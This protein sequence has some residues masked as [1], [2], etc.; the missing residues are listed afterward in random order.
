MGMYQSFQ[1]DE[2][3]IKITRSYLD[4]LSTEELI[5]LAD[6]HG[7]DIPLDLERVFVIEELLELAE[8]KY[9]TEP[10]EPSDV[11]AEASAPLPVEVYDYPDQSVLPKQ[12]NLTYMDVLIRDPLWAYVFWEIKMS[13]KEALEAS[14]D[15]GG[16]YLKVSSFKSTADTKPA[17][18]QSFA[19]KVNND[20]AALYIG[21]PKDDAESANLNNK[22]ELCARRGDADEILVS[23]AVFKL[24]VSA[25]RKRD[26][27]D[28]GIDQSLAVMSG[29]FDF[30]IIKAGDRKPRKKQPSS[31][32]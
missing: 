22:V 23:S 29:L 27:R 26:V 15:F 8:D 10:A 25:P 12:Y 20:D 5:H 9:E 21:F 17:V 18:V 14:P 28:S 13:D 3:D 16:Y 19:I 2:R 24:P 30:P 6:Y 11:F 32:V 4:R 1:K 7:V 31:G